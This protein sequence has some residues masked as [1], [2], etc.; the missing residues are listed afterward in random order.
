MLSRL[1][2]FGVLTL[3]VA[4]LLVL[5]CF[6]GS[7]TYADGGGEQLPDPPNPIGGDDGGGSPL[8]ITLVALLN[9]LL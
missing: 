3:M 6:V 1:N 2:T 5:C 7:V 9:L 4:V 8:V